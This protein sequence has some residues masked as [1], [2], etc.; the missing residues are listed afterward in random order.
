MPDPKRIAFYDFDGTLVSS[1]IVT[2]YAFLVRHLPSRARAIWKFS[3][4]VASVP[5]YLLL[6]RYSRRLFNE[7][8]FREYAGIKKAW[9]EEQSELLFEEVIRPSIYPGARALV[10]RDREQGFYLVLVTG[11]LDFALCRAARYFGFDQLVCNSLVFENDVATG[12]VAEP[13]I[14]EEEKV[15]AMSRICKA[16]GVSLT[17]AKAYSDSFSD[18]SMLEAVGIPAAVNPDGRLRKLA[19]RRGWPVLNL[20]SPGSSPMALERGN[21]VHIS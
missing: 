10:D 16:R 4:L 15:K 2:R 9:L 6:N 3:R 1:N 18:A 14:A 21:H 8:F 17:E 20:K 13:L 12:K 5:T 11:E 7:T 19:A